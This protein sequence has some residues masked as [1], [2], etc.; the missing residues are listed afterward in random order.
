MSPK[1]LTIQLANCSDYLTIIIACLSLL[2]IRINTYFKLLS[3]YLFSLSALSITTLITAEYSIN[4][5]YLYHIMGLF[6]LVF[7]YLLYHQLGLHRI[8]NWFF[9]MVLT[10]YATDSVYTILS[11]YV[12][13]NSTGIAYSMLF[14][15]LLGFNFLWKLFEEEKVEHLGNFPYF[16]ITAG[17]TFFAAGSFFGYLLIGRMSSHDSPDNFFYNSWNIVSAFAILKL[18]LIAIAIIMER[19]AHGK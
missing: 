12:T 13:I 9:L 3:A 10:A 6:E 8:W 2:T 1:D 7:V 17:F 14:T 16:Y 5:S 11:G 19:R 18:V 4:N 15:I